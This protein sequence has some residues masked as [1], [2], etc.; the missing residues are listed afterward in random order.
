MVLQMVMKNV[1][2]NAFTHGKRGGQVGLRV[3]EV[4]E[5]EDEDLR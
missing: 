5:D 3:S 1:T 2:D 4:R